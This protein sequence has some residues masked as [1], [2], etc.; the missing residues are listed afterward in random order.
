MALTVEFFSVV[1]VVFTRCLAPFHPGDWAG[2]FLVKGF[3]KKGSIHLW[4]TLTGVSTDFKPI[5][6]PHQAC[7]GLFDVVILILLLHLFAHLCLFYWCNESI[8][9]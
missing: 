6:P 4:H 2:D 7:V 1:S 9:M 3:H 8:D 5:N